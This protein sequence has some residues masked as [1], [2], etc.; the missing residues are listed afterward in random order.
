M[1]ERGG[2]TVDPAWLPLSNVRDLPAGGLVRI[3]EQMARG[4][5]SATG[6]WLV[7]EHQP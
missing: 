7:V 1:I 2:S 5:Y 6:A 4:R 3:A